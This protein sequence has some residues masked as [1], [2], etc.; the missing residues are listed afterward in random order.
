MRVI[1]ARQVNHLGRRQLDADPL[2]ARDVGQEGGDVGRRS[3][4]MPTR[5]GQRQDDDADRSAGG[6]RRHLECLDR[7]R[8]IAGHRLAA[9]VQEE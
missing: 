8:F 3:S 4:G 1:R 2:V 9:A 7:D 6:G 5:R